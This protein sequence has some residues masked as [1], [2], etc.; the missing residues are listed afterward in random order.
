MT[1]ASSP[2]EE[3][4]SALRGPLLAPDDRGYDVARTTFHPLIDRRPAVIAR[5]AD[6]GDVATALGFARQEG[7]PVAIRGG[8]HSVAGHSVC[9]GGMVIDL[10]L[11]RQV[12]V[13]PSARRAWAGGGATWRDLDTPCAAFGLA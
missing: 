6:R 11:M 12:R 3:L 4:R 1:V 10:R 5:C 2:V 9:D 7:L 8:G 13:D